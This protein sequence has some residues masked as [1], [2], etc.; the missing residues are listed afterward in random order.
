MCTPPRLWRRLRFARPNSHVASS[1]MRRHAI[2]P[3]VS[4]SEDV[5]F[6]SGW[7]LLSTRCARHVEAQASVNNSNNDNGVPHKFRIHSI[8]GDVV[9]SMKTCAPN[10][11]KFEGGGREALI[12]KIRANTNAHNDRCQNAGA[13]A[14]DKPFAS[15]LVRDVARASECRDVMPSDSCHGRKH[16]TLCPRR[17]SSYSHQ[18]TAI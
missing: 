12:A 15:A 14:H 17:G 18:A 11:H 2:E 13:H 16:V 4:L 8:I 1:H 7:I 9:C 3:I 10:V 6:R 5:F